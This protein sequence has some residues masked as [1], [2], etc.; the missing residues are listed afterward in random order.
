MPESS[1]TDTWRSVTSGETR[2]DEKQVLEVDLDIIDV[3]STTMGFEAFMNHLNKEF[4]M[5]NLLALIEFNQFKQRYREMKKVKACLDKGMDPLT[6]LDRKTSTKNKITKI[7]TKMMKKMSVTTYEDVDQTE[8]PQTQDDVADEKSL[9]IEVAEGTEITK[10]KKD[11]GVMKRTGTQ[12][13]VTEQVV[14]LPSTVPLSTI[15]YGEG[16]IE[17]DY[18]SNLEKMK[19]MDL[20]TEAIRIIELLF[21]K[22]IVVGCQMEL[23]L[24]HRLRK[25]YLNKLQ[26]VNQM[27]EQ[28]MEHVFDKCIVALLKLMQDSYSRFRQTK[29]FIRYEEKEKK[30]MRN[31]SLVTKDSLGGI[32]G[33]LM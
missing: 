2:E 17:E 7:M 13:N 27:S 19:Q 23:N 4:S 18:A 11:V 15:V 1:V 3:I 24:S 5:E 25:R 22:Y 28:Q 32:F 8:T 31:D 9:S 10:L 12:L 21:G 30:R 16:Y 6:V 29:A 20:K 14:V 26:N 33:D